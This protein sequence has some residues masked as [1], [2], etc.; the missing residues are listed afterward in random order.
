MA[1]SEPTDKRFR[2]AH[3]SPTRRG[4]RIIVS[5]RGLVYAGLLI[6]GAV[7]AGYRGAVLMLSSDMLTVT[8]ITLA[9]N[10]RLSDG[11]VL[12]LL[13]G[14]EGQHVLLVDL[15]EW[16]TKLRGSAW[17]AGGALRRV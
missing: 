1:V 16:R 14:L 10:E 4:R 12:S 17:V 11:E 15:D 2:R 8:R 3:V 7:Y 9:G 13:Y 5:R 6:I